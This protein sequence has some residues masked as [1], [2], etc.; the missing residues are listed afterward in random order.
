MAETKIGKITPVVKGTYNS[1][2]AYGRLNLVKG[3][4]G[5]IYIAKQA[6]PAGVSL[7][8]TDYWLK[9]LSPLTMGT[10][11]TVSA[12]TGASASIGGTVNA[13]MLN[14]S[15]PR[16]VTGNESI[17]DTKGEGDTD[18]VWS[19]GKVWEELNDRIR[20]NVVYEEDSYTI[21]GTIGTYVNETLDTVPVEPLTAVYVSFDKLA[22]SGSGCSNLFLRVGEYDENN[23]VLARHDFRSGVLESFTTQENTVS[24][25][26]TIYYTAT[27]AL[28]YTLENLR[29]TQVSPKTFSLK[30]VGGP[31]DD[32]IECNLLKEIPS[33]IRTGNTTGNNKYINV[34]NKFNVYP[35]KKY[36]I[37]FDSLT[38]SA[39]TYT[40]LNLSVIQYNA[41]NSV[42]IRMPMDFTTK[43][44]EFTADE[45]ADYIYIG[46]LYSSA[47][48]LEY[49]LQGLKIFEKM[50]EKYSVKDIDTSSLL[51]DAL[52]KNLLYELDSV[53]ING[54]ISSSNVDTSIVYSLAIPSD[55]EKIIVG[56][57]SLTA[58]YDSYTSL[59][60]KVTEMN[61]SFSTVEIHNFGDAQSIS[62]V[63][64]VNTKYIYIGIVYT[65]DYALTYTL[66]GLKICK[67]RIQ[68]YSLTSEVYHE[69]L[70]QD[71]NFNTTI[72]TGNNSRFIKSLIPDYWK[73]DSYLEG[74]RQHVRSLRGDI[75]FSYIADP[76][77]PW[78]T[79]HSY[80]LLMYMNDVCKI[81]HTF[82]AGD[83]MGQSKDV[84]T[85]ELALGV[86]KDYGGML[87][88]TM[89]ENYHYMFGNHDLNRTNR[90]NMDDE[91]FAAC[92]LKYKD[93]YKYC[94]EPFKGQKVFE[95]AAYSESNDLY[96]YQRMHYHVDDNEQKVRYI[97]FNTG[98]TNNPYASSIGGSNHLEFYNQLNWLY[99]TLMHTPSG[100][101]VILMGHQ[102][103][104]NTS[105]Y[106]H[107]SQEETWL[108]DSTPLA[109]MMIG[110][111]N[112]L[113]IEIVNRSTWQDVSTTYN[114][115]NCPDIY[116]LFMMTGHDHSD[117]G[118]V[119]DMD[120]DTAEETDTCTGTNKIMVISTLC[121]CR[122]TMHPQEEMASNTNT[123]HAFDIF[124]V[125]LA[126][127]KVRTTR[128]GAGQN[129]TYTYQ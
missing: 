117:L 6:V 97:I 84:P 10:V 20:Y 27:A 11:E 51:T 75:R 65:S 123:E 82:D 7:S 15:I 25:Y 8:D 42:I 70:D 110:A 24:V 47:S 48:A 116:P 77:W 28:T 76:H 101:A 91:T 121:D 104:W 102:F 37:T 125:D 12:E 88:E 83:F 60:L 114:F 34:I 1:S 87:A 95:P 71:S 46:I 5:G 50:A 127:N 49:T 118:V 54:I 58:N 107:G 61:S 106:N 96:Y 22:A 26:I 105:I 67:N 57:D 16:G 109:K 86:V 111:R 59:F 128:I 44:F 113:V 93:V 115:V 73:E 45:N 78:N 55:A 99:D 120:T 56:Y 39:A 100:Y 52:E 30:D 40:K 63:P 38:A 79:K 23:N 2:V 32:V 18:Y 81:K 21:N 3:S 19:A 124:S 33:F 66:S 41:A 72:F 68:K 89:Y 129:R 74:K 9:I 62:F 108:Q 90:G 85:Y 43:Y 80:D 94:I 103:L 4:D 29:I 122:G 92:C 36:C 14:L 53:T 64:N 17:D 119:Y 126:A 35:N 69:R 98:T 112:K 31:Y 13:P